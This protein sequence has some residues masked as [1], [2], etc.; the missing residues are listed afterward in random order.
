MAE[1]DIAFAEK[2]A[3]VA[4]SVVAEGLD[5]IDAKRTVLYLSL[6]SA[7]IAMKAL[8][9]KAGKPVIEIRTRSHDVAALLRD[10]AECL[11]H[12]D[13]APNNWKQV[14]AT[15]LRGEVVDPNFA[16]ATIGKML[17]AEEAGASKYPN[18]V[19][20]GTVPRHYPPELMQRMAAKLVAWARSHWNDIRFV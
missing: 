10:V 13:V 1:Y 20:Y 12:V 9:E 19:R 4:G 17:R 11:I 18:E 14:K 8:L 6:L 3:D 16:N 15:R 2:L 5:T 7:E